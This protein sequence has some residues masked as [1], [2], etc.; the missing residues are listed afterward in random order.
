M[1]V[2]GSVKFT[3]SGFKLDMDLSADRVDFEK[4]KGIWDDTRKAPVPA[5]NSKTSEKR[6]D[7]K[8]RGTLRTGIDQLISEPQAGPGP[9]HAAL[10][11]LHEAH[12]EIQTRADM[13]GFPT[14][15]REHR[16]RALQINLKTGSA[17]T[18]ST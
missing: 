11:E 13:C 18:Y 9:G 2:V 12:I 8:L 17:S 10:L 14:P 7:L 1:D 4:L 5:S 15:A 16:R 3:P 6:K